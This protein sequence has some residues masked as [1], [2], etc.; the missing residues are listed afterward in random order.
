MAPDGFS[1]VRQE[2]QELGTSRD[3]HEPLVAAE[4]QDPDT[5]D[6][7]RSLKLDGWSEVNKE[8]KAAAPRP[9]ILIG[10]LLVIAVVCLFFGGCKYM[11]FMDEE[12]PDNTADRNPKTKPEIEK[13]EVKMWKEPHLGPWPFRPRLLRNVGPEEPD[14]QKCIWMVPPN[15]VD[16]NFGSCEEDEAYQSFAWIPKTGK[17]ETY[18]YKQCL[19]VKEIEPV[20]RKRPDYC[21]GYNVNPTVTLTPFEA[22]RL[23]TTTNETQQI[24]PECLE[25]EQMVVPLQNG[26]AVLMESCAPGNAWQ[27]WE[28]EPKFQIFRNRASGTCL[29]LLGSVHMWE[30]RPGDPTQKWEMEERWADREEVRKS[31]PPLPKLA[32][33]ASPRSLFLPWSVFGGPEPQPTCLPPNFTTVDQT[34]TYDPVHD[35]PPVSLPEQAHIESLQE[36]T[37]HW[38]KNSSNYEVEVGGFAN[39]DRAVV[40]KSNHSCILEGD[41]IL[42]VNG[43]PAVTGVHVREEMDKQGQEP[44][45]LRVYRKQW[46]ADRLK[47]LN[48]AEHGV[49]GEWEVDFEDEEQER[50]KKEEE[51]EESEGLGNSNSSSNSSNNSSNSSSNSNS[52]N[53]NRDA[54][55][56]INFDDEKRPRWNSVLRPGSSPNIPDEDPWYALRNFL[57]LQ[58]GDRSVYTFGNE[59]GILFQYNS[60]RQ[61]EDISIAS[62]TKMMG[63]TLIMRLVELGYFGL[64]DLLS[65]WLPWWP[66]DPTDSRS[67]ITVRH[68][69]SMTSGFYWIPDPRF[70]IQMDGRPMQ[71]NSMRNTVWTY[72]GDHLRLV[73]AVMVSATGTDYNV[74]WRR[75]VFYRTSPKMSATK[76]YPEINFWDPA[77]EVIST[78]R[79]LQKFIAAYYNKKLISHESQ[80]IIETESIRDTRLRWFIGEARIARP[81]GFGNFGF[82]VWLS[83]PSFAVEAKEQNRNVWCGKSQSCAYAPSYFNSVMAVN[84]L[85]WQTFDNRNCTWKY[86]KT[87]AFYFH[88][89]NVVEDASWENNKRCKYVS[90][91]AEEAILAILQGEKWEA[92]PVRYSFADSN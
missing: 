41:V 26:T 7:M 51:S 31:L 72:T 87:C 84:K 57:T 30:C 5:P 45:K 11:S 85:D 86:S 77:A 81:L 44:I 64:D 43:R 71:F 60:E 3:A 59:E 37:I 55:S 12:K 89:Q 69:I 2:E 65:R 27:E 58:M 61:D 78:P 80:K 36:F 62:E 39:S 22:R 21:A 24:P 1:P 53:N 83:N 68:C 19:S 73:V 70:T 56:S 38:N 18:W 10:A 8:S 66:T 90:A 88:L 63:A 67:Y 16:I 9:H 47:F 75:H 14:Q 34:L 79:D 29:S 52:S 74:L 91:T 49:D 28:Y 15:L 42:A 48:N 46:R 4:E 23:R 20:L 82:D 54:N 17:L 50:K 33:D 35:H 92:P 76:H 40:V 25:E 13:P 32:R 6:P